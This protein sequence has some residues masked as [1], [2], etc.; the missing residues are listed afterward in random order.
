MF[1]FTGVFHRHGVAKAGLIG[2][3]KAT[4]RDSG[5]LTVHFTFDS[6]LIY[7]FLCAG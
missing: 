4:V 7:Y 3:D 1:T 5:T 6:A 2:E